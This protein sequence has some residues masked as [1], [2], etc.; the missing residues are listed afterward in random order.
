MTAALDGA[1][2]GLRVID[3][4]QMLAG[5]YCTMLLA[6]QGAEVIKVEP[7]EGDG[8]RKI[9]AYH[10]DDQLQA[11][12]GY[13]QSVNRNKQSLAL[14][15]KSQGGRDILFRLVES[16]DVL[17]E[18]YRA[19]VMDRLGLA[20]ETLRARNPRL[21][22][23]SI[24]GFGDPRTGASPYVDW[25]AFDVVAQA[26]GGIMAITGPDPAT[27]LKVGPGVGDLIPAMLAAFGVLA[28]VH[29]AKVSG[30]GQYVDVGMADCIL[31]TC[32]RMVHQHSYANQVPGPEGNR[33]PLLCPFGLVPAKDGWITLACHA[34]EFWRELCRLLDRHDLLDDPRFAT[35]QSR[36]Q[37]ADAVYAE[38]GAATAR[39]SKHELMAR[40]G[41]KVPFGPVYNVADII[42]DPHFKVREMIVPVEHPGLPQKMAIAGVPVRL[43]ETPGGV[44]RRAPILG[45]HTTAV[46][47]GLGFS[48]AEVEGFR[49]QNV[50]R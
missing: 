39:L 40:L 46:L 13:F 2:A 50:V 6:D 5:P 15:L 4:T 30:Q 17:V 43:S 31:A 19:G 22:Y 38:I 37:H 48:N 14:D 23:A 7:I 11:Y 35:N 41:G 16:A 24:R 36:V 18:N 44:R 10:P 21:V 9:T 26:M 27:P 8:T 49:R 25:P 33:H 47:T 28:A 32:E 3:L 42:A 20:Y 29:R 1:L 34:D 45:E 12:C